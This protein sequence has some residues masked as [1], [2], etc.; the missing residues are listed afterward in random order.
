V[1]VRVA[2][3]FALGYDGVVRAV[4]GRHAEIQIRVRNCLCHI[5][6]PRAVIGVE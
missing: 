5:L 6:W 1:N 3:P 4:T 2:A